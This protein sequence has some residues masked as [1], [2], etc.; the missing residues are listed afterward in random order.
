MTHVD[1]PV[2]VGCSHGTDSVAG[3]AAIRSILDGIRRQRPDLDVREAFVDV[4][5]PEV[6]DVVAGAVEPD[7]ASAVVVPLLLSVGFHVRVDIA[8]SVE[9]HPAVAAA[10]LGPDPRLVNLLA[11]RL[12]EAGLRDDDAVVLAAAGS[13]D[14]AAAVAVEAIGSG[15]AGRLGRAVHI[16]YGAGTTPRVPEAVAAA[17]ATGAPRVVVAAY[18]LAP[19]FFHD[20]VLEAGGDVVSAPLAPDDRLVAIAL[21]RYAAAC[22]TLEVAAAR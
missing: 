21:D 12:A 2:L 16:G 9:G 11:D 22:A 14:P 19:G 7:G 18:L 17:R 3:R 6:P 4:Q 15:L 13:T 1:A 8:E 10:P 5:Q 20:R